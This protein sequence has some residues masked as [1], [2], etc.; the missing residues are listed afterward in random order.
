MHTEEQ[1][2]SLWCKSLQGHRAWKLPQAKLDG[3]SV[4]VP[5]CGCK[6]WVGALN[7][8]G[9]GRVKIGYKFRRA[10]IVAWEQKHGKVPDGYVL[11]HLCR[12]RCCINPDH[13]EVVTQSENCSRSNRLRRGETRRTS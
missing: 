2:K 13:L 10:H 4:L 8:S 6:I 9:Y 5:I 7:D 12:V 3:L 11:D 1:A